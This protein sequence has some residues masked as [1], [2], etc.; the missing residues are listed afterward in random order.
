MPNG[1]NGIHLAQE[2]SDRYPKLRVLLTTGYS[3]V[4]AAAQSRF[5]I[6]RKPFELSALERAVREALAG[7]SPPARRARG[8]AS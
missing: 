2:V 7:S 5:A 1:M 3:D 8:S 6:L 4:A